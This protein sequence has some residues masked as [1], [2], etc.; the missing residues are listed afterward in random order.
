MRS[1]SS[2]SGSGSEPTAPRRLVGCDPGTGSLDLLLLIDGAPADQLR[3]P[4][5]AEAA[6]LLEALG[7][8]APLDLIAG[9]SGYGLPLVE[10]DR[11]TDRDLELMSLVRPE[12][13]GERL[14]VAGF[15][16]WVEALRGSGQPV[17]FLPGGVHLPS[18]PAYRKL[19]R[20]DLGTADKIAVAA[21]ALRHDADRR[22]NDPKESSFALVEIG[23]AFTA[24]LVVERG[25]VVDA[26]AGT[27]GPMGL[28]SSGG[29]DGEAAYWLGPLSKQDLFHGGLDDLGAEAR[30]AFF[31]SIV[32]YLA[33]L[34]AVTS[35]EQIYLSGIAARRDDLAEPLIE[36]LGR[37]GRVERLASLP[38]AWVKHAAQGAALIAD[39]LAGGRHRDLVE[40]LRLREAAGSVLDG[41]RHRRGEWLTA[42][43]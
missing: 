7:R 14:G 5:D 19:H 21:L 43:E 16:A 2:E 33:G 1:S 13:R 39:G 37:F 40:A 27:A 4:A 38:G 28:R 23:S 25:A 22:G 11:A 9:P 34:S 17:V 35:F 8:W 29:W 20:I 30:A 10:A 24:L 31:E 6:R 41:L 36:R 26:S 3:L 18:I 42:D 32:K 15:S 12:E